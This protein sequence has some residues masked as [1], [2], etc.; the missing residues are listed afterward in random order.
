VSSN[1]GWQCLSGADCILSCMR[2]ARGQRRQ[3]DTA[4]LCI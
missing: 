4:C 1:C 2:P 3:A